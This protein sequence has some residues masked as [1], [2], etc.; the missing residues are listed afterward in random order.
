M[1][2]Q[3]LTLCD[4]VIINHVQNLDLFFQA[5]LASGQK[6]ISPLDGRPEHSQR[7]I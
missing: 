7:M 6:N 4:V 1:L 3:D 5:S 2:L